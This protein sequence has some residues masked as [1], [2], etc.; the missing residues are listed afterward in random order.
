MMAQA[1]IRLANSAA[2]RSPGSHPAAHPG[3]GPLAARSIP[4]TPFTRSILFFSTAAISLA[5]V[6]CGPTIVPSFDSPEPAARNSAIVRAGANNDQRSIP[7]LV[8]MLDSDDPTTRLLAISA[9]NRITGERLGYDP[10][11]DEARREDSVRRWRSY[12][13]DFRPRGSAPLDPEA[14]RARPSGEEP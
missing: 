5:P 12:A 4:L 6:S 9:L 7:D 3:C 2:A 13:N 11:E 10:T 8:R 14:V 1:K